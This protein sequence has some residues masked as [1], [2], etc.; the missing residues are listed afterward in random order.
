MIIII[1]LEKLEIIKL[2]FNKN[3]KEIFEKFN[4]IIIKFTLI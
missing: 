4:K 3:K 1:K 2:N